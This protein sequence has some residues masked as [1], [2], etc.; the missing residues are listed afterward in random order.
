M[1]TGLELVLLS[2]KNRKGSLAY[3]RQHGSLMAK[4]WSERLDSIAE[5]A[6]RKF[7]NRIDPGHPGITSNIGAV[8]G[9]GWG[10]SVTIEYGVPLRL[11]A[12]VFETLEGIDGHARELG[13]AKIGDTY[14]FVLS[15][16]VHM[17]EGNREA[18]Y[19]MM[20]ILWELGVRKLVLTNASG[21]LRK[22]VAKG[23]IVVI[24][25][26]IRN[27]PSPL[28]GARFN[29]PG[30]FMNPG[31]VRRIWATSPEPMV[32]IGAYIYNTGPEFESEED[33]KNIDRPGVVSVGMSTWPDA[34]CWAYFAGSADMKTWKDGVVIVALSC[35]SNGLYDPHGHDTNIAVLEDNSPRLGKMLEH[36]VTTIS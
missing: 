17:F 19:V 18:L 34:S 30:A 3:I 27:G 22:S 13:I 6:A 21:G 23:D 5:A 12:D 14:A 35:V 36:V 32:H 33:R 7:L 20:R 31:L 28:Q 8:L 1:S 4:S 16:R 11:L 9:T 26:M 2:C 24:D 25:G 10:K 29:D 15:G